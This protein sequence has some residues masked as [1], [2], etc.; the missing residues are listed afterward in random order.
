MKSTAAQRYHR[1]SAGLALLSVLGLA[2]CEKP[3]PI[4]GSNAV[5]VAS[6]MI[7]PGTLRVAAG[8]TGQ[9]TAT[10]QDASGAPLAGRVVTW[11]STNGAYATVNS[12]GMVTGVA[13][14]AAT[15]TAISEGQ[16][17]DAV[18]IG[19]RGAGGVRDGDARP[20]AGG[21]GQHGA[22][23]GDAEGRERQS[24]HGADGDVGQWQPGGGGGERERTGDG[25]G[26]RRGD[27]HGDERRAERQ[28]GHHGGARAGGIGDGEP[29]GA[30]RPGGLDGAA[31]RHA[32]GCRRQPAHGPDGDVGL[33]QHGG[34]DGE[35]ERAGD[36]GGGG[37]G[38]DHGDE[39][40]GKRDGGADGFCAP[41]AGH[42]RHPR[43]RVAEHRVGP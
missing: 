41:A 15:I 18:A 39:R 9:L 12:S 3:V 43:G 29:G 28:R 16:S 8:S 6:V 36:G 35:R 40:G 5:P 1:A 20:R 34:G 33:E 19:D 32:E 26:G 37:R 13:I 30:E 42:M 11:A 4:T 27:D 2:T 14:G 21:G 7:T 17:G 22:A 25:R 10:P 23:D 31:D 38:D 24:A